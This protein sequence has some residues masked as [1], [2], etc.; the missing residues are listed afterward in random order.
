MH[1]S[2]LPDNVVTCQ[3]YGKT[4]QTYF[5]HVSDGSDLCSNLPCMFRI[6][7]YA[8]N[9]FRTISDLLRFTLSHISQSRFIYCILTYT[10]FRRVHDM[11]HACFRHFRLVPQRFIRVSG[12]LHKLQT[13]VQALHICFQH[14]SDTSNARNR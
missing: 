5:R 6:T 10:R 12:A 7:N 3:T 13:C 14:G 1:C 11:F 8:S 2:H 9:M 4:L